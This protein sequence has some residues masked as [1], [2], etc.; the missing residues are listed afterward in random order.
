MRPPPTANFIKKEPRQVGL[1]YL[2]NWTSAF[3]A[4]YVLDPNILGL[5]FGKKKP[6][7][8]FA[9]RRFIFIPLTL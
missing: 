1:R 5:Y 7:T 3:Q 8:Y 4:V 9:S 2:V 6:T